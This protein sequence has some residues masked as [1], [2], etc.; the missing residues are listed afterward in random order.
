MAGAVHVELLVRAALE[1]LVERALAQPE[2]D[3]PLREHA[4]GDLVVVVERRA[5]P[6]RVDARELRGEH[7]LVDVLLRPAEPAVDRKRARDVRRVALVLAAG[8]DQQQ[9]AVVH[10]P[11]VLAVVQHARVRARRRRS[12]D[13]RPPARRRAG[14]R[15]AARPRPGTRTSRARGAPSR[16]GARRAEIC[17]ARRISA[18]SCAS[19]TSRIAS[20]APRTSTTSSGAATPV[21][22]RARTSFSRS[23]TCRS[24]SREQPERRVQR[25]AVGRDVGQLAVELGDRM[26]LV[27]AEHLAAP[28]RDRSESRPRS[29]APRSSRGRTARGDRRRARRSARRPPRAREIR[30][31][32]RNSCRSGTGKASRGCARPRARSARARGRRRR[33]RA[34]SAAPRRGVCGRSGGCGSCVFDRRRRSRT[35]DYRAPPGARRSVALP[36]TDDGRQRASGSSPVRRCARRSAR[37]RESTQAAR[38]ALP[39]RGASGGVAA[40][41]RSALAALPSFAPARTVL[42]TLPFRS[43]WD[44]RLLVARRARRRARR[45]SSPR[46]DP[47]TRMLSTASRS[48]TSTRDVVAGLPRAFPSRC[49][50]AATVA[51]ATHRLGAGPRARLRRRRAPPRLRRRLLRPAA[52]AAAARARRAS[53]ARSR[54]RSSTACPP[55]P[56]DL[57]VDCIV[58][59]QRACIGCRAP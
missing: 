13:R 36:S 37:L 48:S 52:A 2:I 22:T 28:H 55:A 11:V 45:W 56:H 21:R 49:R 34:W 16:A 17:A 18:S 38:D 47:A 40:N 33:A 39:R 27:E 24:Q 3:E 59:E 50:T 9:L 4:L 1:H 8:V 43:E 10:L 6:H 12:T 58:T 51:A 23:V 53:P 57:A 32:N 7:E 42:V 15:A 54:C 26:R 30:T 20:S 44:S 5:G 41:R 29:R 35:S 25:R 46:V 31:G 19:L 14:T